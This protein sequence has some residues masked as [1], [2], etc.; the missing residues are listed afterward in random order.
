MHHKALELKESI[1]DTKHNFTSNDL[2]NAL[3]EADENMVRQHTPPPINDEPAWKTRGKILMARY[4]RDLTRKKVKDKR[5]RG[6]AFDKK[7]QGEDYVLG[8]SSS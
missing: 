3:L 4:D 5:Q 8:K 2:E 7:G 1:L 6:R